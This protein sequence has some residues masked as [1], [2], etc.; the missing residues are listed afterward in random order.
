MD[1]E[2]SFRPEPLKGRS[3]Y[4]EWI[5]RSKIYFE[6]N[7]F[8]SYIDGKKAPPNKALYTNSKG[9]FPTP[10][11]AIKYDDDL[12]E[13][14][15]NERKALGAVRSIISFDIAGRFMDKTTAKDLWDSINKL[16]GES[17]TK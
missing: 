4:I 17:F 12:S 8:M 2:I 14:R 3:N 10:E 6:I 11:L 7:G 13:Y 1:F 15:L 16:Y 5:N 9:E